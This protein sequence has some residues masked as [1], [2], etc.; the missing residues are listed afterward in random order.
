MPTL[1]TLGAGHGFTAGDLD[2]SGQVAVVA[3]YQKVFFADG[4]PA[5]DSDGNQLDINNSGFHKLD[6]INTRCVGTVTGTFTQGE[7]VTQATSGATGIF[8]ENVGSGATAWSLIYR[9][10]TT[11]FDTSNVITGA[12]SGATVTPSSVVAPPHWLNWVLTSGT[13]PDGGSNI[14]A[15]CFGR[16]VMNSIFN[17]H[18]WFTSRISN[19]LDLLLVTGDVA[20]AV[21]SQTSGKA[22]LIGDQLIAIIPHKDNMAIFGCLNKMFVMRADPQ[23]GGFFA[24]LSD[25]TGIFSNTSHCWDDK[26]N[27]YWLGN[28]GLY[29]SS[30]DAMVGS[31]PSPPVNLTKEH[32][33]RLISRLALNR[34][35][36]RVTMAYDKDRYGIEISISQQDGQWKIAFWVDLRTGGVF[37]EK[38]TAGQIPSALFY[39]DARKKE[40]RTLLAGGYDGYIRKWDETEKSD[41][42]STPIDS[43]ALIGPLGAVEIRGKITIDELSVRTGLDTD[44]LKIAIYV[45]TTTN[46]LINDVNTL[47]APK[48]LKEFTIDKLL[49]SIR[50][51]VTGGAIGIKLSNTEAASSW[52]I[53]KIDVNISEVGRIK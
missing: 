35:T 46:K 43:Y 13:F 42:D 7:V 16:I 9:T 25:T 19:P 23:R 48:V 51:S 37:P 2:T 14:M 33:P 21:S 10:D 12:D 39:F 32:L 6:F 4:R 8:D 53:E 22:G 44:R 31:P 52:S 3:A 29:V 27:F 47:V 49:P 41:D 40:E 30:Y 17:P 36:D 50:Q 18:Q 26:N 28:D 1:T 38:Y 24:T 11:E 15:L 20:S 5:Y 45:A 34:G